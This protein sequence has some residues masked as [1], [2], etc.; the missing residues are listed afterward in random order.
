MTHARTST[1]DGM[2]RAIAPRA[3][4]PMIRMRLVPLVLA[5]LLPTALA[6]PGAS[7]AETREIDIEFASADNI[8]LRGVLVLPDAAPPASGRWPVAILMHAM[9][10]SRE[11]VLPIAD[12]LA[13][14]G[15]ASAVLDQRGHGQ[16]R[17]RIPRGIY[18]FLVVSPSEWHNAVDDQQRLLAWLAARPDVDVSRVVL[19]GV[20]QAALVAAEAG[21]AM[22]Q[23]KALVIVDPTEPAFGFKPAR[24]F[25][26]FGS[27]P[28][29]FVATAFPQSLDLVTSYAEYGSGERT[30]IQSEIFD[31]MDR[32][33]PAHSDALAR[34]ITWIAARYGIRASETARPSAAAPVGEEAR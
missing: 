26:L 32:A 19:L 25:G 6:A 34:V 27:R 22:P 11:A 2:A 28:V 4:D 16:S 29:L 8:T 18:S 13:R 3:E 24:D 14:E 20:G 31:R 5:A 17:Q 30:V 7:Y 21:P 15:I 10:R 33:L 9:N 1:Q 12:A 23:V